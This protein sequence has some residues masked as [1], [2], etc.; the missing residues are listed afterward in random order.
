MAEAIFNH[1]A[2]EGMRAIS[3]GSKPADQVDPVALAVL[4]EIGIKTES[5]SP[6]LLTREITQGADTIVT[7]GC[8]EACPAVGKPM[9][10]WEI[11]DPSGE[12]ID[13]YRQVRDTILQK[14]KT[15]LKALESRH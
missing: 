10:D 14:V 9:E 1:L 2:P 7:M 4:E 11:E 13:D 12:D 6:K 15:L 5:L 8:P 3:A